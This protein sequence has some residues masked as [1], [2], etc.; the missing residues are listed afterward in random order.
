MA[1]SKIGK[2][3]STSLVLGNM[4]GSGI[5]LLPASLAAYGQ[6]SIYGWVISSI[7]ALLLAKV[8][9]SLSKLIPQSGGPYT[10]SRA[11]FGDF[12]GFLVAWGY[13]ISCLSTNAAIT[14][15]LLGYLTIFFPQLAI[16]PILAVI[17]GVSIIWLLTWVNNRGVKSAGYVQLITTLLKII[18][19]LLVTI[20]GLFYLNIDH[21][22]PLNISGKTNMQALFETTA[23]TLFAF[24]GLECATIPAESTD[25]PE[26]TIPAATWIGT[27]MA[28]LIYVFGSISIMGILP[29]ETLQNSSA[30]FADA[31]FFLWGPVGKYLVA[32]G[33]II[34]TFGA[35]NGWILIQGQIPMAAARDGV[36]PRFFER[37]N[38]R[39][40]PTAGI[41]LSSILVSLLLITNY[42][43]GLNKAFE[44]MILLATL[45]VLVPFLF[46]SAAYILL[47]FRKGAKTFTM[48]TVWIGLSAFA[49]SLFAVIGS[50]KDVV[51]W[52]FLMLM[53][54]VPFYVRMKIKEEEHQ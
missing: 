45:L 52:G 12:A 26:K 27:I 30:P 31:A 1:N 14:V 33:A 24:L 19:L 6:I 47:A 5:F 3:T 9:A 42:T 20:V 32:I 40:A 36:F 41:V 8:F 2:W 51:F 34:S 37:M 4:I 48:W 17:V 35:L 46:S 7:G 18:P 54:G 15:A 25:N 22:T 16:S 23:L 53:L 21:F 39:M 44:F 50:G 43:K 28:I 29:P 49:F 10:Y 13:W 11:G 38:A